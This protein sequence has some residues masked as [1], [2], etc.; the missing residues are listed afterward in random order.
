LTAGRAAGAW[1]ALLLVLVAAGVG[2]ASESAHASRAASVD[3]LAQ[4]G[5]LSAARDSSADDFGISVAVSGSTVVVG[6]PGPMAAGGSRRPG[7]V[8]VF[9]EP[10]GGW[11]NATPTAK[12]SAADGADGD[13]LGFSVAVSGDTV[14][15]GA[16]GAA[17]GGR[18]GQGAVYVFRK[19][20]SGWKRSTQVA[21]LTAADGSSFDQLGFSVS[22]SDG[23]IAAGAPGATIGGV[24]GGLVLG[25]NAQGATYVFGEPA[26]GWTD[27]TQT[28]K[29]VA[30]DGA[31]G[32]QLG[33][34]VAADRATVVAGAPN[35]TV[36]GHGGQGAAYLFSARASG[37]TDAVQ[38]ARL[39]AADG[40]NGDA[41]GYSVA[42]AGSTA[43]AGAP[44]AAVG[45]HD[46]Q[47]AAYVF[48][49]G[50]GSTSATQT[51]K[52]TAADG[53]GGDLL[54]SA[55]A[56]ADRRVAAGAPYA[57]I[58][59][60]SH[61][62]VAYVFGERADGWTQTTRLIARDGV[63]NALLGSSVAATDTGVVAGARL[64]SAGGQPAEGAA[65][66]FVA[67]PELTGVSQSTRRWRAG[68]RPSP[69]GRAH[70]APIGTTF[71]FDLN[72]SARVTFDFERRGHR[73]GRLRLFGYPGVNTVRFRGRL[74]GRRSLSPGRYTLVVTA[75][76]AAGRS[77]PRSLRF[78]IT[79]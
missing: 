68:R 55:V 17:V 66:V 53:V 24:A 38:T 71:R 77:S 72:V 6:A 34:S 59:G 4:A 36:G 1:S 8:Y 18:A 25:R 60:Q 42:L 39:T 16:P 61:Q 49:P 56:L 31:A 58:N 79:A 78:A 20:A 50:A 64:A 73:L 67:P 52:L 12:L 22:A 30:T 7:A 10:A 44:S 62:G 65:Y 32:D 54:G 76:S 28:A 46:D 69:G 51:A 35:A 26:T 41:L 63:A 57:T 11:T 33:Y 3:G 9:S 37:W 43:V 75:T 14:V 5:K 74:P 27:S 15:A 2:A 45:G 40:A 23:T 19:L 21:K 47:G 48:E 29:L 70:P 13:E